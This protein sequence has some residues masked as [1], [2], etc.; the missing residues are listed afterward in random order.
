MKFKI[1]ENLPIEPLAEYLKSQGNDAHTVYDEGIAG[2]KDEVIGRKCKQEE[3]VLI[4]LDQDFSDIRPYPP[5][6]YS[7]INCIAPE[8][9]GQILRLGTLSKN[10]PGV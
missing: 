9:A 3:R 5:G 7:G 10:L 1:D 8:T 2:A 4:T 6:L